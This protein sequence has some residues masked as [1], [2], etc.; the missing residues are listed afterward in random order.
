[1]GRSLQAISQAFL[2]AAL[3]IGFKSAR[4]PPSKRRED[5]LISGKWIAFTI[6]TCCILGLLGYSLHEHVHQENQLARRRLLE[7][8]KANRT[9]EISAEQIAAAGSDL[10]RH[11]HKRAK[12]AYAPY[13]PDD[14]DVDS[15]TFA[16]R[17]LI[18]EESKQSERKATMLEEEDPVA[19]SALRRAEGQAHAAPSAKVEVYRE[20]TA[21][22]FLKCNAA[23]SEDHFVEGLDVDDVLPFDDEKKRCGE[24]EAMFLRDVLDLHNYNFKD[25]LPRPYIFPSFLQEVF[26][27]LDKGKLEKALYAHQR[28][29][30]VPAL[31]KFF[32]Y[33]LPQSIGDIARELNVEAWDGLRRCNLVKQCKQMPR[34]WVSRVQLMPIPYSPVVVITDWPRLDPQVEQ[35]LDR[36]VRSL[37]STSVNLALNMPPVDQQKVLDLSTACM[38][39]L[40]AAS[41]GAKSVSC[42]TDTDR[43][44]KFAQYNIWLNELEQKVSIVKLGDKSL[45]PGFDLIVGEPD[46]LGRGTQAVGTIFGL[47]KLLLSENGSA[48]MSTSIPDPDTFGTYLCERFQMQ[49]FTG[50][51]VHGSVE[52]KMDWLY[53]YFSFKLLGPNGQEKQPSPEISQ[54][55]LEMTGKDMTNV[56]DGIV[57]LWRDSALPQNTCGKLDMTVSEHVSILA[58]AEMQASKRACYHN[59]NKEKDCVALLAI[60]G[61]N[62]RLS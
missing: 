3:M 36:P 20:V 2:F 5:P 9:S 51:A 38:Q 45:R 29:L 6:A 15:V 33:G 48:V 60:N 22:E 34:F 17:H 53:K 62:Y 25:V 19:L 56:A 10:R 8:K 39:G 37:R 1:V 35:K 58:D 42:V 30:R 18:N 54:M 14:R 26:N 43:I 55:M 32:A 16:E 21:E 28:G 49:G 59:R 13:I 57:F 4:A 40:V 7:A 44:N 31:V 61:I 12:K 47:S 11:L 24:R 50:S 27:V 46:L 52:D 41:R 23:S